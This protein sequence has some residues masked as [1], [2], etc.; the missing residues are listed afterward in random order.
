[1]GV[2]CSR[3]PYYEQL[4]LSDLWLPFL[5]TEPGKPPRHRLYRP[6]KDEALPLKPTRC[7]MGSL[8]T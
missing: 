1:M 7:Q 3:R 5:G 6:V 4:C 8:N 2:L